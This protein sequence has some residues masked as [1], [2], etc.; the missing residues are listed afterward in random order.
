MTPTA[1]TA[2]PMPPGPIAGPSAWRGADLRRTESWIHRLTDAERA[3][4]DVALRGVHGRDLLT[5]GRA[6]FPL[7]GFGRVLAAIHQELLHG[8][9][10]VLIRGLEARRY[11]LQELAT[12]YWGIGM[13]VGRARSQNAAGHVLGHVR[14]VGRDEHD[15]NAR[16]YQTNRRQHYHTDS[17]DVVGL[18]CV[19]Q[20][21]SGGLSS[22]VTGHGVQRDARAPARS[23]RGDV[24]A[25]PHRPAR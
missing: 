1:T 3:E 15:P 11:S 22:I 5:I 4:I 7:P 8:R 16:I 2:P 20:A 13:H 25:V 10:F 17:V 19:N 24:R 6:D 14:D 18:L 23:R 21:Q 12:I 9:G